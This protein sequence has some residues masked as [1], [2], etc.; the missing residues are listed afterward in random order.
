MASASSVLMWHATDCIVSDGIQA[1]LTR[2]GRML[3]GDE[4]I[5]VAISRQTDSI[6]SLEKQG[7]QAEADEARC[8]MEKILRLAKDIRRY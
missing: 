8:K 2:D 6:R 7:K 4:P 1:T 3:I 5:S